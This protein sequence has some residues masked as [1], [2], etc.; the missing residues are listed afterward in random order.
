MPMEGVSRRG[1][2]PEQGEYLIEILKVRFEKNMNRHKGMAWEG[3]KARLDANP[4]KLSALSAMEKSG[5][6]PDV[7]GFSE[8]SDQYIF[9]DCSPESPIGRRSLCYDREAQESRK[10]NR[11]TSSA[12]DM[13]AALGIAI[14]S[15][16]E[17]RE[18]QTLGS[19]DAKTSSWVLTPS[20]IRALGGA[21]FADF[22]YGQVFVYHNSAPSYFSSRGFRGSL[23]V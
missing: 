13:A 6:E 8:E 11:P 19:F 18:L 1:I 2:S 12:L 23:R 15:V 17:Y 14:L 10:E 16:D 4:D 20:N 5:G 7:V 21:L 22:R 9:F 3:V